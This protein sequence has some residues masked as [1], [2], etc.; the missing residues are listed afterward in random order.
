MQN[1]YVYTFF[2]KLQN[3]ILNKTSYQIKFYIHDVLN[4]MK[5]H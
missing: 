2:F 4:N 1:G 5:M 3:Q